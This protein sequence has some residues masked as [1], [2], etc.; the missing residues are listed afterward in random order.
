MTGLNSFACSR[1]YRLQSLNH[2]TMPLFAAHKRTDGGHC[3][4]KKL[5]HVENL[6]LAWVGDG[7]ARSSCHCFVRQRSELSDRASFSGLAAAIYN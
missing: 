2:I 5:L 3:P 6:L 7:V 4:A 1:K